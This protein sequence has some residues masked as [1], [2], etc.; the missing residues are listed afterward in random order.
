MLHL[1]FISENC[2]R[3]ISTLT[4]FEDTHKPIAVQA[5]NLVEDLRQFSA[6]GCKKKKKDILWL[7][8]K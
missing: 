5:Y 6:A 8:D 4:T 3:L 7:R 1:H 2:Q